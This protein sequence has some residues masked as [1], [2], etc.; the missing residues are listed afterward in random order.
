MIEKGRLCIKTA[1]RDAGMFCIIVQEIDSK[2]VMIDGETR[3]R[4][5]NVSHLEPNDKVFS[6]SSGDR[7]EV[8]KI[9]KS[10]LDIELRETKPKQPVERPKQQ[11]KVK[12]KVEVKPKKKAVKKEEKKEI[13]KTAA[14]KEEK[15]AKAETKKAVKKV[16]KKEEK[17][18]AE[19]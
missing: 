12:E 3:R 6:I 2:L 18:E 4:K 19:N 5:C 13:K 17:P 14:K 7:E 1:G 10:E 11:R 9:F 8:K 16:A 15:P